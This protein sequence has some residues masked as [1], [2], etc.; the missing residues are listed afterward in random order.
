MTQAEKKSILVA[1]AVGLVALLA[2]L[3]AISNYS[4]L[5]VITSGVPLA[6]SDDVQTPTVTYEASREA[7]G[8]DIESDW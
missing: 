1:V 4:P 6:S 7:D 5:N 3:F 8:D 2:V